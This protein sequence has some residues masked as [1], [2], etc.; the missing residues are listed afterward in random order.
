MSDATTKTNA[1]TEWAI[2]DE[3][4]R[5]REWGT[6]RIHRLPTPLIEPVIIVSSRECSLRLDDP[7]VSRKHAK[8]TFE[9]GK[10]LIRD[11]GSTNGLRQDNTRRNEFTLDPGIEV[12]LG[13]TTLIAES[14][15][16]IELRN[17]CARIL[18]WAS[19]RAALVDQAVRALRLAATCR[20]ALVLQGESDPV[21]I[22]QALH[23]R[24]LGADRPFILADPRRNTIR[25]SIRSTA[26]H[27]EGLPALASAAGGSLCVRSQRLPSDFPSLL[28]QLREPEARAQL[29]ICSDGS[30]NNHASLPAPIVV[31]P[32]C[33]RA[34]ELSRIIEEYV[35]DAVAVLGA[36][37]SELSAADYEWIRMHATTLPEIEKAASRLV[38][39]RI[40]CSASHAAARLGMAQVSLS[41]WLSRRLFSPIDRRPERPRPNRH[42]QLRPRAKRT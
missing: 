25:A 26:N 31:P 37:A 21:P 8:L 10:W 1:T 30:G 33:E 13:N 22:A 9:R 36:P 23:H 28:D 11:L 17:F 41:R 20:T 42:T 16:S 40:S 32:L 12:S 4:I 38:A 2:C 19:H 39:L 24:V 3:V 6:E 14:K 35:R 18:G 5:L 34:A 7:H 15:R 27:K 29:F